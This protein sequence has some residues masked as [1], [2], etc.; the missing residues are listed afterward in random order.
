ME[1]KRPSIL[2]SI[3][4]GVN[5]PLNI[6]RRTLTKEFGLYARVLVDVNSTKP[7]PDDILVIRRNR[8]FFV[9]IGYEHCP[10]YCEDCRVIGHSIVEYRVKNSGL[11]KKH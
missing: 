5:L 2:F 10:S 7:L 4:R 1:Y 6:D 3:A 9:Y 11:K 8:E